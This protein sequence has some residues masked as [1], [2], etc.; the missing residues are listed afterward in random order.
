[1]KFFEASIETIVIRFY[2]MMAAVIIPFLIGIPALAII[3]LPIFLSALMGVKF[4]WSIK[5][6]GITTSKRIKNTKREIMPNYGTAY[7]LLELNR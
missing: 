7:D 3:A 2:I 5:N 1:M 6:I 4:N